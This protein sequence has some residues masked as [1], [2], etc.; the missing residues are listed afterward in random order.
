M[1]GTPFVTRL[2]AA[3]DGLAGRHDD[4]DARAQQI[5]GETPQARAV[6]VGVALLQNV[7]APLD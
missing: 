7:V 2:A 3:I 1:T 5:G 6:V 4:V